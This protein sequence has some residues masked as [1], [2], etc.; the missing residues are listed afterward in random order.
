MMRLPT[1]P[2]A[3]P[4]P[5]RPTPE[6]P[7]P[8][9]PTPERLRERF[10]RFQREGG[11]FRVAVL[12]ACNLDCFFCHNEAMPNPR[13]LGKAA[14]P[15]RGVLSLAE[16]AR[17][18]SAYA[19]LGGAQ[20]NVTG[21]EPLAHPELFEF[22]EAVDRRGPDGRLTKL[23]LNSNVVLAERLLERPVHPS[24]SGILASLHTTSDQAFRERLGGRS[25]REVMD[26]IAALARHGYAVE[27]NYSLGPYNRDEFPA[28]LDFAL[29]HGIPLKAI[30]LVR[31]DRSEG[32]YGGDWVD[33]TW[34]TG[35][36]EA[37]GARAKGERAALGGLT[38]TYEVAGVQVKV[39]NV[40]RGRLRT[41]FCQGCAHQDA[42]G[43]GI[44]GLRVGVDG[45]WKPCLLR[46]E[47]YQPVD[48]TRPY[49]DQILALIDAMVG[50][51]TES[52]VFATG[53]PE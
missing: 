44:Y 53:A 2:S 47:R 29:A 4:T 49:E 48:P 5:E 32:F 11:K 42:C 50:D 36:L 40:A 27:I 39:K 41:S 30:A 23:V 51:W 34:L 33:P 22:L 26:N 24:L 21:G 25:A 43:E 52:A 16:L 15:A 14:A 8:E 37:R 31:P 12:N 7:T 9:R 19:R 45:Q 46:S 35:P 6:R 1:A 20:V 13:R 38:T 28:V 17:L 10:A 3:L 18:S